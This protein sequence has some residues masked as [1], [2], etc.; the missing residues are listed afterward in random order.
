MDKSQPRIEVSYAKQNGIH[1]QK[2]I[3]ESNFFL[4]LKIQIFLEE[5]EELLML[6]IFTVFSSGTGA[7]LPH[8]V[9]RHN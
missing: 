7:E 3:H 1:I 5:K 6:R 2:C 8:P 4:P 9:L